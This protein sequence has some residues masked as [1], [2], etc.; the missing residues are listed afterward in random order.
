M[1]SYVHVERWERKF[2][3]LK[4]YGN[5]QCSFH[6]M[7]QPLIL[8]FVESY[9]PKNSFAPTFGAN[10]DLWLTRPGS[11]IPSTGHQVTDLH[12]KNVTE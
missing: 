12:T 6:Y 1:M 4:P 3:C 5:H 2:I 8:I 9:I 10:R 11:S 7:I